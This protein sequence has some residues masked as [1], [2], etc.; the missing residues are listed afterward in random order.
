MLWL[1]KPVCF[2]SCGNV[3]E[4]NPDPQVYKEMLGLPAHLD[5]VFVCFMQTGQRR[6][7]GMHADSIAASS[8]LSRNVAVSPLKHSLRY[9]E[10]EQVLSKIS[11]SKS[12]SA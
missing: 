1:R 6:L 10:D 12:L 2:P 8:A 7:Q 3:R 4:P 5:L 9:F 11:N